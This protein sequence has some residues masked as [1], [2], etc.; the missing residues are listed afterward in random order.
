MNNASHSHPALPSSSLADSKGVPWLELR[1][2]IS[3]ELARRSFYLAS[4]QDLGL[5]WRGERIDA[6]ERRR[7]ISVFAAQHQWR[8][9]TRTDGSAA[10]FEA[11]P[12]SGMYS[13]EMLSRNHE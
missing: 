5:L 12:P 11:A 4:A 6:S 7:R 10:R 9:E 3:Q 13:R 1:A 2:R 8:V